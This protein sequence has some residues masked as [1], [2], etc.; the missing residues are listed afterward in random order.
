M[1]SITGRG[2]TPSRLGHCGPSF[3]EGTA[4]H[5]SPNSPGQGLFLPLCVR[6]SAEGLSPPP[7][8]GRLREDGAPISCEA[9]SFPSAVDHANIDNFPASVNRPAATGRRSP[10]GRAYFPPVRGLPS[11]AELIADEL[12]TWHPRI[13]CVPGFHASRRLRPLK[14]RVD[15]RGRARCRRAHRA[16]DLHERLGDVVGKWHVRHREQG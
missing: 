4:S 2:G 5:L 6:A 15:V 8:T 14:A 11:G 7:P 10:L 3:A 13:S 12:G 9:P 16:A 1:P